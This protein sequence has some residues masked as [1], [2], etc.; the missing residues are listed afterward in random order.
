MIPNFF[1]LF[2]DFQKLQGKIKEVQEELVREEVTGSSGAGMVEVTVN[3][4]LEVVDIKIEKSLL[5]EKNIGLIQDLLISAVNDA[6]KKAQEM[7]REKLR[8][9][10]GGLDLSDLSIPG[11][12]DQNL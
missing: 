10:A 5:E 8:E 6:L 4:R 3:G 11:M 9:A 12:L 7:I 1:K 2:K